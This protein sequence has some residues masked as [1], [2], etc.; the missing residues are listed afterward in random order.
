MEGGYP[1]NFMNNTLSEVKFQERTQ[2]LLQRKKNKETSVALR[3]TIPLS[4]SKSQRNLKEEVVA[5]KATTITKP[6]FQGD[7]HNRDFKIRHGEVLLEGPLY[8]FVKFSHVKIFGL[9]T[10]HE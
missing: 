3:K 2:D 8:P 5:S 7:A 6:N 10:R 1:Q 4:T 9:F